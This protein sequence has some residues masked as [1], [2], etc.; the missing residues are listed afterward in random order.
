MNE[1]WK[2]VTEPPAF[3]ANGTTIRVTSPGMAI[4]VSFHPRSLAGH[5]R[6]ASQERSNRCRR[7]RTGVRRQ[8]LGTVVGGE[9]ARRVELLPVEHLELGEVQVDRVGIDGGVDQFP[10]FEG[11]RADRC[12]GA[13]G[14]KVPVVQQHHERRAQ[15]VEVFDQDMDRTAVTGRAGVASGVMGA[16]RRVVGS[17]AVHPGALVTVNCMI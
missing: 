4:T 2:A 3:A 13:C 5:L 9:V 15:R 8:R 17:G 16:A 14:L 10:L 12:R 7:E 11:V 6:S 1:L